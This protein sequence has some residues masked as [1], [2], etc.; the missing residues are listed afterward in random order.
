MDLLYTKK[1]TS[2]HPS[3]IVKQN[4]GSFLH[5]C[6]VFIDQNKKKNPPPPSLPNAN[7]QLKHEELRFTI[8]TLMSNHIKRAFCSRR[9]Q[10][11]VSC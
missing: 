5:Y 10:I 11:P 2:A 1:S 8:Q 3:P 6:N 9:I 4:L 7:L